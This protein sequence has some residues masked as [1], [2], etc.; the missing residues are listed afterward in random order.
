MDTSF[1]SPPSPL[2]LRGGRRHRSAGCKFLHL[3]AQGF[4]HDSRGS[5]DHTTKWPKVGETRS[6]LD[7]CRIGFNFRVVKQ[8]FRPN[9]L[10]SRSTPSQNEKPPP[11]FVLRHFLTQRQMYHISNHIKPT[12]AS[13]HP[14]VRVFLP[15]GRH[16][17][18]CQDGRSSSCRSRP[19]WFHPD[20]RWQK[21]V[22]TEL[23]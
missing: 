14:V 1:S 11:M 13:P 8:S 6:T 2:D 16:H 18:R 20:Q 10:R 12:I 21:I 22:G 5:G 15:R 17:L 7:L 19:F 23:W 3:W 9:P 4:S